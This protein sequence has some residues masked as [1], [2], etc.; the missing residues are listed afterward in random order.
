MKLGKLVDSGIPILGGILLVAM[1]TLTFGQIVL[2]QFFDFSLNWSDEVAQFCMTWLALI[3]SIWA[4]KNNHHLNTGL[5]LHQKL[6]KKLINLIDG[7]LALAI[8][9]FAIVVAYQTAGFAVVAMSA[10]S[11]SLPWLKMGYI[12]IALPIFMLTVAYYYLKGFFE[13]IRRIFKST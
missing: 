3:G 8:A 9:G 2:R 1:V 7:I 12:F 6:N 13:N 4:T 11:L 10:G 5:K